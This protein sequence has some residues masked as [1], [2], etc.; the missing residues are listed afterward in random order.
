[1]IISQKAC[2][3]R[4]STTS[5]ADAASSEVG[6]ANKSVDEYRFASSTLPPSFLQDAI[7]FLLAIFDEP[8][9][10]VDGVSDDEAF[11]AEALDGLVV[12]SVFQGAGGVAAQHRDL[13][14]SDLRPT[15]VVAD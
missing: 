5:N 12:G 2:S 1:M 7:H 4:Q 8:F 3:C 6:L 10:L 15:C 13:L 11:G 9:H 14:T